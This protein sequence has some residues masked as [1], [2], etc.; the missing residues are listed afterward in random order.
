MFRQ[1]VDEMISRTHAHTH[2]QCIAISRC[3]YFF[4]V[5]VSSTSRYLPE[6]ANNLHRELKM[7][8]LP[9]GGLCATQYMPRESRP[10]LGPNLYMTPPGRCDEIYA[11]EVYGGVVFEGGREE[12]RRHN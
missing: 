2:T 4:V 11:E 6:C 9:G 12:V 1:G 7:D 5:S 3:T 8:L 10:F